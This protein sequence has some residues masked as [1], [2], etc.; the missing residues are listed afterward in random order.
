MEK[1]LIVDDSKF[2]RTTIKKALES[3][4]GYEVVGEAIDGVDGVEQYET[5][6]PD[7][8]VADMEMPNLNGLEMIKR[9]RI[10]SNDV[11]IVMVTSVANQH[12]LQDIKK[13]KT[14]IVKKPF[15]EGDLLQAIKSFR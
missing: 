12:L 2:S 4:G 8:I 3:I 13:L 6:Q 11:K 10:L 14:S 9:I 1:V 15:K 5:L 7:L